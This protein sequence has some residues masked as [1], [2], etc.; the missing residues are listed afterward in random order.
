MRG[1]EAQLLPQKP[2]HQPA[3][4]GDLH[5]A[6]GVARPQ[7]LATLGRQV[8]P[9]AGIALD[10]GIGDVVAGGANGLLMG[11]QPGDADAK[12]PVHGSLLAAA[13]PRSSTPMT[14]SA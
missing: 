13:S 5:A 3:N 12:K 6:A 7:L 8:H 10:V 9:L 14:L 4:I 2:V 1:I 11:S